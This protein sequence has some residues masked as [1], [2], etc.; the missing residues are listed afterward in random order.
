M[1]VRPEI[2]DAVVAKNAAFTA[3]GG[4]LASVFPDSHYTINPTGRSLHD[5][6]DCA[7][8]RC[9]GRKRWS[10]TGDGRRSCAVADPAHAVRASGA[11]CMHPTPADPLH[12]MIICLARS[13]YVRP[14]RHEGKSE[15][16]H[17][18]EGELDVVLFHDDGAVREVIRMG[19]YQSGQ[20]FFYRLM[21]PC[22]HTVLVNTPHVLLHETTNGP[23]DPEDTEY[24]TWAPP[25]GRS[26]NRV[27]ATAQGKLHITSRNTRSSL[28]A[29]RVWAA[30]SRFSSPR[31]G[32]MS[33]PWG[34]IP[35]SSIGFLKAGSTL[36]PETSRTRIAARRAPSGRSSTAVDFKSRLPS[37]YR[38]NGDSWAGEF[39][40]SMTATKT[41]IEGLAPH[42]DAG[43]RSLGLRGH[44][45]REFIR[46]PQP[47]TRVPH[48]EGR[49]QTDGPLLRSEVRPAG[50]SRERRLALHVRETRSAEYFAGQ[51]ELQGSTRRSRRSAGWGRRRKSRRRLRSF[52]GP[53]RRS[54]PARNSPWMAGFR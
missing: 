3:R 28:A 5:R 18:I 51:A 24:A 34:A 13:T 20:V 6:Y 32:K 12:E 36:W 44:V 23:F 19:P 10:R 42:F 39:A 29:Q 50:D 4:R 15:S 1:T 48:L 9:V 27:L 52:A 17:I 49:T 14:H 30:N 41:L 25:E 38:G 46:R 8:R 54:S 11:L 43:R 35:A 21:E 26:A 45:E 37:G 40:V 16:F 47:D 53:T 2:E 33:P 22:F 7:K 31:P